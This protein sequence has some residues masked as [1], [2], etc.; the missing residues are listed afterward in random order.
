MSHYQNAEQNRAIKIA[1]NSS[2]KVAKLRYMRTTLTNQNCIHEEI[3][4]RMN[5]MNSCTMQFGILSL[6]KL[7]SENV[8]IK[9]YRLREE[10]RMRVFDNRM[11]R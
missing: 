3:K 7:L 9:I 8:N 1:N 4:N 10:Y 2:E 6:S 11:L 5:S